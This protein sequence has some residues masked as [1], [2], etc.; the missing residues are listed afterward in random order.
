[1]GGRY[2]ATNVL[3]HKAVNVISRVALDH[4]EH[5]GP[6]LSEIAYQKCG[7]FAPNVPIIF[8]TDN[9]PDVLRTIRHQAQ[10]T[11]SRSLRNDFNYDK[12]FPPSFPN[13]LPSRQA[14][15]P[16]LLNFDGPQHQRQNKRVAFFA[17]HT[18]LCSL[19]REQNLVADTAIMNAIDRTRVPGRVYAVDLAGAWTRGPVPA[20]VD[21]AHNADAT[22]GVKDYIRKWGASAARDKMTSNM[23]FIVAL[24]GTDKVL[25]VIAPMLRDGDTVIAVE[26]NPVAGMARFPYPAEAIRKDLEAHAAD[27][28]MRLDLFAC[29]L[30][31]AMSLA[32]DRFNRSGEPLVVTGSLYIVSDVLRGIRDY[33][34]KGVN[35]YQRGSPVAE[36]LRAPGKGRRPPPPGGPVVRRV[37]RRAHRVVRYGVR[38][39]RS[40]SQRAQASGLAQPAAPGSEQA[41]APKRVQPATPGSQIAIALQRARLRGLRN[42]SAPAGAT[43]G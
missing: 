20:M 1:M 42:R 41:Q 35:L 2:D 14:P 6:T 5:L 7:I 27:T 39:A 37:V 30:R 23:T 13:Y 32:E 31:V 36:P 28:G 19:G 24:S 3:K 10:L 16:E 11:R 15:K 43:E 4:Q 21:G 12:R 8:S 9:P 17:A 25:E 33:K 40:Q 34:W 26:F 22:R 18:L 29:D 38:P